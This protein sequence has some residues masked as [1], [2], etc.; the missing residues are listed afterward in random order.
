MTA[1]VRRKRKFL[2]LREKMTIVSLL[3]DHGPNNAGPD[4]VRRIAKEI[5]FK[6][7]PSRSALPPL[8]RAV[9]HAKQLVMFCDGLEVSA[10]QVLE[11]AQKPQA[12]QS[13]A[14]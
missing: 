11:I 7:R 5:G 13:A 6:L 4:V 8:E 1:T 14:A 3:E 12:D 10:E 2:S 9:E